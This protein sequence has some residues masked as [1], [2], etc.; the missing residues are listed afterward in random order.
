MSKL[1]ANEDDPEK[2]VVSRRS[3]G[4]KPNLNGDWLNL[5]LL[6]ILYTLQG[7]LYGLSLSL[8]IIFQSKK[9]SYRDQVN[10]KRVRAEC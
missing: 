4:E 5:A 8:P 6:T 10:H 3:V 2:S 1:S 9:V 7:L